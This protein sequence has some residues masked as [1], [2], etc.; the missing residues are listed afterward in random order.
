MEGCESFSDG[1][2]RG[3][4]HEGHNMVIYTDLG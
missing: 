4:L 1:I 2:S 3:I